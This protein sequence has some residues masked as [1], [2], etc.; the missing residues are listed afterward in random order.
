MNAN[1]VNISEKYLRFVLAKPDPNSVQVAVY[2]PCTEPN[3]NFLYLF[4]PCCL[5]MNSMTLTTNKSYSKFPI[6]TLCRIKFTLYLSL[7][8]IEISAEKSKQSWIEPSK[9]YICMPNNFFHTFRLGRLVSSRLQLYNPLHHL[10]RIDLSFLLLFGSRLSVIL[11]MSCS[12][13]RW[14][15]VKRAKS[16]Q[17]MLLKQ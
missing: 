12:S 15:H 9:G 14:P 2:L 3:P 1:P 4:H 13:M 16:S 8:P 11:W 5:Y 6:W 17:L 10:S 7:C